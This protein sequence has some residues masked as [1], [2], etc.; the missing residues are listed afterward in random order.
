VRKAAIIAAIILG[1]LSAPKAQAFS[2]F[3]LFFDTGSTELS[4]QA[5]GLLDQVVRAWNA[6]EPD[7]D[8]EI[9]GHADRVG[10]A[11]ANQR[12]SCARAAAVRDYLVAHG[13]PKDRIA[14]AGTGE[15][16]PL[17]ETPDGVAEDQNRFVMVVYQ[18]RGLSAWFPRQAKHHC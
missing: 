14:I 1:L 10:G 6:R 5:I 13:L 18:A 4:S 7:A 8:L 12:L 3:V 2:P 16:M 17:V 11:A 9:E 15:D